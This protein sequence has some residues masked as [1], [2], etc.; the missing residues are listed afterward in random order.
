[1]K[2][3]NTFVLVALFAIAIFF[4]SEALQAD[5]TT[6]RRQAVCNAAPVNGTY[7]EDGCK[8]AF[9]QLPSNVLCRNGETVHLESCTVNANAC[10]T[11]KGKTGR[12]CTCKYTC[13]GP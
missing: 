7:T 12:W 5:A 6:A 9:N 1:M 4:F 13:T 3:A 11:S 8:A 10:V 2:L